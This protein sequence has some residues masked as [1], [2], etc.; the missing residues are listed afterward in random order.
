M[1]NAYTKTSSKITKY[2][3]ITTVLY[4]RNKK[5]NK[6]FHLT[7]KITKIPI[8]TYSIKLKPADHACKSFA[9][10]LEPDK[11]PSNWSG[12]KLFATLSKF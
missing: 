12:S 5:I 8:E 2:H 11:T 3:K 7:L 9:N 10:S 6:Y 4:K 1:K